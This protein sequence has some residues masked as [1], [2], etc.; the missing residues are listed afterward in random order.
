M[1]TDINERL[2]FALLRKI[3]IISEIREMGHFWAQNKF[4]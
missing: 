2:N 3:V 1:K 4:L